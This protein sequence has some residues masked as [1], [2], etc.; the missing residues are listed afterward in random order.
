[1]TLEVNKITHR[2][3][4]FLGREHLELLLLRCSCCS[5]TSITP[6]SFIGYSPFG[7]WYLDPCEGLPR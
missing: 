5:P 1:M 2:L 7:A 3:M 4:S 6:F